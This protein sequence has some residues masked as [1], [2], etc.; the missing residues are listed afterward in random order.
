MKLRV[1]MIIWDICF[2]KGRTQKLR[3]LPSFTNW[4]NHGQIFDVIL[5][6]YLLSKASE[7]PSISFRRCSNA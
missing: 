2:L 7:Q 4:K 1:A 6:M 3:L 5:L